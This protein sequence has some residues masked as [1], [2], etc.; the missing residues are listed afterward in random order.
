MPRPAAV[1]PEQI[2]TAVLAMLAEADV[3]A[4]RAPTRERFRKV[5]SVRKLRARLGAGDP[6]ML[7]RTLNLIEAE[8]VHA[9]LAQVAIP[10]LPDAV[11]EQMRALWQTAVTFQLDEVVQ[12]KAAAAGAAGAAAMAERDAGLRVELLQVE[13]ADLRAQI[14]VR[15]TGLATVRT[16]LRTAAGR[17]AEADRAAADLRTAL[18]SAN[19]R[20]S[21][22]N[23]GHAAAI[24]AIHT[25][26]EGLSRQLLQE[27]EHQRHALQVE[28]ERLTGQITQAQE[29]ISALE[30]LR[31]HLLAELAG[32][33]NAHQHAAGEAAALTTVIAGQQA[34]LQA[35]QTSGHVPAAVATPGRPRRRALAP[36]AAASPAATTASARR[37]TR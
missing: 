28:R 27:T 5:V 21:T 35:A 24:A 36:T 15:D 14:S 8:V 2:R 22:V 33:R 9:G 34:L 26:Y 6:T 31:D 17:M 20:L 1:S 12:M 3:E 19:A 32:A 29:R 37:K 30:G 18:A 16:E 13:L 25:R 10:G 23:D 7:S 11:A 4:D